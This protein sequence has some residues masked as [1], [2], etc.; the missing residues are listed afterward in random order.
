MREIITET[1]KGGGEPKQ[2]QTGTFHDRM[3][4][5]ARRLDPVF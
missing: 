2:E 3:L 1:E 4:E 5:G